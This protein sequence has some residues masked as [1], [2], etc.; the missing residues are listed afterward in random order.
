MLLV[1]TVIVGHVAVVTMFFP[2]QWTRLPA[3]LFALLVCIATCWPLLKGDGKTAITIMSYGACSYIAL[4]AFTGGGFQSPLLFALPLV[5]V[6]PGLLLGRKVAKRISL[7]SALFCLALLLAGWMHLLPDLELL[8]AFFYADTLL[9]VIGTAC[10]M[11]CFACDAHVQ[12]LKR[13]QQLNKSLIQSQNQF[14]LLANNLPALVMRTD[15]ALNCTYINQPFLDFSR[16]SES[17]IIGKNLRS[18][19]TPEQVA[20]IPA[21]LQAALESKRITFMAPHFKGKERLIF[22][23]VVV[24]ETDSNDIPHGFLT[25]LY[26]VTAREKMAVE[27][28]RSATHDFLTGV[29][30]RMQIEETLEMALARAHRHNKYVALLLIDL[31]GFKQI[32]DT[33]GHDAGDQ[34]LKHIA[35]QLKNTVRTND[36]VGRI[37]GDEFVVVIEDAEQIDAFSMVAE[38]LLVATSKTLPH[39]KEVL[40]VSASI[41]I[42]LFPLHGSSVRD[43]FQSADTAMYAAKRAGKNCY[44]VGAHN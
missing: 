28:H 32:N 2:A 11:T 22:E 20:L 3:A 18:I 1:I 19:F 40:G 43:L 36:T 7:L 10:I 42:A 31:D 12:R 44:R 35:D 38:K 26:D 37:G 15:L 4:S 6:I 17:Q 16:L 39:M 14:T 27:L 5:I 9:A 13:I 21:A 24:S 34:I 41:G 23:L 29:A 33:Y 30:N 8:P 25:V